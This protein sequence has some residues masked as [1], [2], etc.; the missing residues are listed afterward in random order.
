MQ[1][2]ARGLALQEAEDQGVLRLAGIGAVVAGDDLDRQIERRRI[3]RRLERRVGGRNHQTAGQ[4]RARDL[5]RRDHGRQAGLGAD[6]GGAG[7]QVGQEAPKLARRIVRPVE[8]GGDQDM[9]TGLRQRAHRLSPVAEQG[10]GQPDQQ[11][12][13]ILGIAPAFDVLAPDAG[14][15]LGHGVR[16]VRSR[17]IGPS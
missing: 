4:G 5:Q 15:R 1:R 16:T 17:D 7:R 9:T 13:G 14:R 3:E 6:Q 8:G 10:L 12:D 11:H 2:L